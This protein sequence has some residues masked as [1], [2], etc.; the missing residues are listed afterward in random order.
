MAHHAGAP[1]RRTPQKSS[2]E[3][4]AFKSGP[5][6]L[7]PAFPTSSGRPDRRGAAC[8][9]LVLLA[10]ILVR[11]PNLNE[12][13]WFDEVM[14]TGVGLTGDSLRWV[15]FHDVH[16]PLYALVVWAWIQVFGDSEIA[17]RLPSLLCG[18]ASVA[19][20]FALAQQWFGS[21]IAFLAAMLLALSPAH[22]WYSH[23]N[24]TNML[25]VL[26]TVT[27]IWGLDR[28]WRS[29]RRRDWAVFLIASALALWTNVFAVFVVLAALLWLWLE[30][31][32]AQRLRRAV[33][34]T[35]VV[36]CACLPI[37][38]ADLRQIG[39]LQRSYLRPFT[40]E[41]V[42]K[43]LL[44]YLSHGNTLRTLSPYARLEAM[45]LQ[46][47]PFFLVDGFFA[48]LLVVG[49]VWLIRNGG[50]AKPQPLMNRPAHRLL[51]FYFIVPLLALWVASRIHAPIYIERSMLI[52][53]VPYVMLL[54]AGVFAIPRPPLR[55]VAL[56]ALLLLNGWALLNLWVMK[57]DTWTVYKQKNDWR[58]AAQ[59]FGTEMHDSTMPLV[60]FATAPASVLVYYDHRFSEL[61]DA[62]DAGR[63]EAK[64]LIAYVSRNG[65]RSLADRLRR[66]HTDT[67]YLIE[68]RYWGNGFNQLLAAVT[69]DPAFQLLAQR[70]FKG[71]NVFKFRLL[72]E[73]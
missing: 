64:A 62:D 39:S 32:R 47:W 44:I 56:A 41:E 50:N 5:A 1:R 19:L 16:P 69:K 68:D 4:S 60:I 24:K 66:D 67:C 7:H 72:A 23:E 63:P 59:F 35:I 65:E 14:Y 43:L 18:L 53:L 36:I 52:L 73:P 20:T 57:S 34:S 9:W 51:V 54:A 40:L 27:L 25:L 46:P 11:L 26:L 22:I 33:V 8:L 48:C 49:F 2:A 55:Y 58:T 29:D 17:V 13:L 21:R 28:A 6:Q 3:R 42:Y 61:A 15:L 30:A 71:L 31:L 37:A 38:I 45:L 10:A 12:S 70:S